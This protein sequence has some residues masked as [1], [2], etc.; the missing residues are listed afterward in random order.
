MRK[1]SLS[2]LTSLDG[3]VARPN[4]DLEWFLTDL[5]FEAEMI[6]L[7]RSV[8]GMLFGRVAYQE[9]AQFWPSA[10]SA[11]PAHA[12]GGFASD[13][14]RIEFARL[15]NSVPKLVVS[16]TLERLEWG[17]GRVLSAD[18]AHE[19]AALKREPGRELVLFAGASVAAECIRL[20][21]FD[22][23]RLL[24]HPIVLGQGLRLFEGL[25][26]ER[27]LRLLE[28]R[29]FPCGVVRMHYARAR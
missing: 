22:E 9:L 28:S 7:L 17:P 23:Y 19:I 24:V 27:P 4:R 6:A 12:P 15:M 8:D 14:N 20:D 16:R 13:E 11:D 29:S 21:V 2:I 18:L 3:Y 1:L 10:G 25:Q 5:E 26:Q